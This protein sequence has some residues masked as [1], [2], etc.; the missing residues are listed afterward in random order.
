MCPMQ[1]HSSAVHTHQRT[2]AAC[3]AAHTVVRRFV[4]RT[5]SQGQ[6]ITPWQSSL[7]ASPLWFHCSVRR[8]PRHDMFKAIQRSTRHRD[9]NRHHCK[10]DVSKD[11]R[12]EMLLESDLMECSHNIFERLLVSTSITLK[13]PV[14]SFAV[15][16]CPVLL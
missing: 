11:R 14:L 9:G 10:G 7:C 4:I 2:T 3:V 15:A 1:P 13:L 6:V 16:T 5:T 8:L 12:A